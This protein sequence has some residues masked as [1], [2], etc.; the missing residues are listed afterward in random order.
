MKKLW[1]LM[2][3]LVMSVEVRVKASDAYEKTQSKFY[4]EILQGQKAA[5]ENHQLLAGTHWVRKTSRFNLKTPYGEIHSESGDFFVNYEKNKVFV[6][7]HLGKLSIK[8]KDGTSID[9]PPGFE[10]WISEIQENRKNQVGFIHP[11]DMK[12]H[13]IALGQVWNQDSESLKKE[14]LRFQSRWGDRTGLAANYY[15][16]LA[17]R[18]I[19]STEQAENRIEQAKKREIIRREANRKLLF[20]RAFG[21]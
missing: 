9:L 14:M 16:G 21:R 3:L 17:L 15:K 5:I 6:V 7:N 20:E 4:F 19:A 1:A 10:V 8:L 11:V 2:F 18:K 12:D 13:A